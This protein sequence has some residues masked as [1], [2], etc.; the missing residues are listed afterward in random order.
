MGRISWQVDLANLTTEAKPVF[1]LSI[2]KNRYLYRYGLV[3]GEGREVEER[4]RKREGP[5]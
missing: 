3:L 5:S 4:E 1:V 2:R